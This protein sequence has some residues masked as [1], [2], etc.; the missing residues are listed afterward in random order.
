M[1]PEQELVV[2]ALLAGRVVS[3]NFACRI[4]EICLVVTRFYINWTRMRRFLS[5]RLWKVSLKGHLREMKS[6]GY[7]TTDCSNLPVLI[8]YVKSKCWLSSSASQFVAEAVLIIRYNSAT[9]L[10]LRPQLLNTS[11]ELLHWILGT[12]GKNESQPLQSLNF[13]NKIS[14]DTLQLFTRL[15]RT[16]PVAI[17]ATVFLYFTP[18]F[19]TLRGSRVFPC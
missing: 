2:T 10:T 1:K 6:L 16:E 9:F 5:C 19:R 15:D 8:A 3:D 4:Q 11:I 18:Y 7:P 14:K 13:V 12:Q 17:I